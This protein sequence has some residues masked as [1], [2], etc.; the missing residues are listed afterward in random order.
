LVSG[1][2]QDA[3]RNGEFLFRE[4][5]REGRV[6]R[7]FKDGIAKI[8]GSRR[9]R[10]ARLGGIAC[11]SSPSTVQARSG[12][13]LGDEILARF[14]DEGAQA[15]FDTA[16]DSEQLVTRARRH[17]QCDAERDVTRVEMLLIL[18]DVF[19]YRDYTT[20][21][22]VLERSRSRWRGIRRRSATR[23]VQPTRS[24]RRGRG[25]AGGHPRM[26]DRRACDAVAAQYVPSLVMAADRRQAATGS[27]CWRTS[28]RNAARVRVPDV[29]VRAPTG[30][31]ELSEQ[32]AAVRHS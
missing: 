18:G 17:G 4:L 15:F 9:S 27:R 22:H 16:A 19:D 14:W 3:L 26:R 1:P 2:A 25:G 12:A 6:F 20:R 11:T 23:W 21:A 28:E 13:R 31:A 5:V 10:R 32:L 30:S 8:S 7:S 29:R 24:A